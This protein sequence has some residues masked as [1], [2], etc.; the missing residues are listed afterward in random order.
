MPPRVR[1]VFFWA[2]GVPVS[3]FGAYVAYASYAEPRAKQ[4][5]AGFCTSIKVGDDPASVLDA[6]RTSEAHKAFLKW[7]EGPD[8]N[9]TLSVIFVGAPPFSRHVCEV[10][11]TDR[12]TSVKTAHVD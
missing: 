4:L 7:H 6:A 8:G 9:R 1:R 10:T 5:A 11:A 3:L 2:L 12:V